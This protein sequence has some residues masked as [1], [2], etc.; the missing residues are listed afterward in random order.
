MR[1]KLLAVPLCVVVILPPATAAPQTVER[2]AAAE[3]ATTVGVVSGRVVDAGSGAPLDLAVVT[4][5]PIDGGILS[6]PGGRHGSFLADA[7]VTTTG[8]MGEYRVEGLAPGRYRLTVERLGYRPA[9]LEI[10]LRSRGDS[11]VSVGLVIEPI[12]LDALEIHADAPPTY[13]RVAAEQARVAAERLRQRRHLATDVRSITH[14]DVIEA[15]TLGE[16]DL[17]RALHRLPGVSTQD[18]YTAE[19]WIRGAPWDQTRVYFDGLPLFHPVHGVG[20]LSGISTDGIGAALL[21]PGVQ[22]ASLSGG[23]AALVIESRPG[24]R[25]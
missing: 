21:H 19:L 15:V 23:A 16:T 11:R 1:M 25:A 12:A 5:A 4:I 24:R 14:T 7:L 9:R 10:E 17:F 8:P 18:D 3:H 2:A 13:G 6:A 22:P 20:V